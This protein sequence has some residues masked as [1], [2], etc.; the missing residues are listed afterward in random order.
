MKQTQKK[1]WAALLVAVITCMTPPPAQAKYNV[2]TK[3]A[4]VIMEFVNPGKVYNLRTMRNLPYRVSNQSDGPVDLSVQIELPPTE[5]LKPGYETIPDPSW[6]RLVPN[7]LKLA[8]G[9]EGLVDVILQVPEGSEYNGR[10]FQAHIVCQTAEPP[11]GEVT[12][13]TFGIALASRLRFSVASAGPEEIKRMQKKGIYQMLNFTLEPDMQY[14]PGF[15]P[16]NKLIAL[17]ETGTRLTLINRSPQKLTFSL[18][19]VEAP[20]GMSPPTGYELGNP[21]WIKVITP[22]LVVPGDSIKSSDLS[23]M[24]PNDPS[25]KGKRLMFVIQAGL[26]GRE[27]PVEVYSRVYVNVEK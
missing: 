24:L 6:V 10:H 18:K 16:L 21:A 1:N 7:R 13:L 26:E 25:L 4:D 12:A 22:Q 27:I 23:L 20:G 8:A 15:Q 9:E 19:P 3:F 17:A 14:V 11:P 2:A 5:Q